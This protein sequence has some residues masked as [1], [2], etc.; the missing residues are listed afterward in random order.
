MKKHANPSMF[1]TAEKFC[2]FTTVVVEGGHL[3]II[4]L[5]GQREDIGK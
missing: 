5:C 2:Y 3:E 1:Q 4:E